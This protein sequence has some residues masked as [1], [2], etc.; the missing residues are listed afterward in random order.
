MQQCTDI[1]SPRYHVWNVKHFY[2]NEMM[3]MELL[4][5]LFVSAS[6]DSLGICPAKYAIE[7]SWR[8]KLLPITEE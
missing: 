2:T 7:R 6:T 8:H 4:K 1:Y 3:S 5:V